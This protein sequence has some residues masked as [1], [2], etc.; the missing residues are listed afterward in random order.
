MPITL[1]NAIYRARSR[2]NEPAYPTFPNST[3]GNP[4]A[5]FYTDTEI[6]EWVNDG[7][8]DM[9]RRAEYLWTTDSTIQIPAYQENPNLPAPTYPLLN[10]VIRINRVEFQVQGDS[11]RIYPLEA[12]TQA[13]L[14]NIWT[15]NQLSTSA[16][17]TFYVTR[18][19][20][21]GTGRNQFVIQI[22]PNPAQAGF[23]NVFYYRM[24]TRLPD[25]VANPSVYNT[26]LDCIE[27][28]DDLVID[29]TVMQAMI[30][31]RS[32]EWQTAQQLYEQ[33]MASII[34]QTRRFNDQAA[35]MQYDGTMMPWGS[36]AW[37]GW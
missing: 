13:Y 19:Y 26:T 2:L 25:P 18:G 7:L 33:K 29:Y 35:Y 12:T 1:N 22:Y 14:D 30:K 8:R 34:D 11:T 10:D 24:P 21:G 3:P 6:T 32:P 15:T 36:D 28:W 9:A 17:P 23:L 27:G 16:Y 31:Q 20:P 37:G 5:R 4:A